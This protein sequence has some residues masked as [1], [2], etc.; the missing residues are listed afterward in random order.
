MFRRSGMHR[1]IFSFAVG[2]CL[3]LL[4][5][6]TRAATNSHVVLI[7][8]DGLR[9][10]FYQAPEWSAHCPTLVALRHAGSFARRARAVYPSMTYCSHA[11]IATGVHPRR[12]GIPGNSELRAPGSEGRGFWY[13]SDLKVP[14]LWDVAHRAGQTVGAVSWPTTAGAKTID[15]NVPEFWSTKFGRQEDLLRRFATP[16]LFTQAPGLDGIE[17][18]AFVTAQA[19]AMIRQFQP[20]LLLVHFLQVDKVQHQQGRA[21]ADVPAALRRVDAHIAALRSAL[22]EAGIAEQTT[23]IVLGDHGFSDV[24]QQIAPNA[25][26]AQAGLITLENGKVTGWRAAVRNTGGSAGVMLNDPQ[27][28]VAL[29]QA[30]EIL[31]AQARTPDGR[32]LY[33]IIETDALA[34][35]GGPADVAFYLEA[36]APYMFSGSV[37][38]PSLVSRSTVKGNHGFLPEK[39]DMLT[40]LIMAGRGVR[41]GAVV[42]QAELVDVAP[43]VAESLGLALTGADGQVLRALLK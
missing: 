24:E 20:R 12:H 13:A 8:V 38:S 10:E 27:D 3:M 23:V 36:D 37:I 31:A 19:V 40:G 7:S 34:E 33:R 32:E 11:S 17:W 39:P 30:R 15:W 29:R 41:V 4:P 1:V 9:P 43:T 28:R 35:R 5:G 6:E 22:A 18:D 26:L 16:G 21:G 25:W 14:A 42:E 2:W